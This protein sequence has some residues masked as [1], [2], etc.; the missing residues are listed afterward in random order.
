MALKILVRTNL[1]PQTLIDFNIDGLV[2]TTGPNGSESQ[3]FLGGPEEFYLAQA[4]EN[5]RYLSIKMISDDNGN[6]IPVDLVED[7]TVKLSSKVIHNYSYSL[8]KTD[9]EWKLELPEGITP[10][11]VPETNVTVGDDGPGGLD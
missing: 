1:D 11:D 7:F 10:A 8:L 5:Y 4:P 2:V 3:P 6:R 9:N